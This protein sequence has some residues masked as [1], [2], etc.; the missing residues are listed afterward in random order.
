MSASM[1]LA[2][3]LIAVPV[4]LLTLALRHFVPLMRGLSAPLWAYAFAPVIFFSDRYFSEAARP[5]RKKFLA[6]VGAFIL[7]C[8]LLVL[9]IGSSNEP[10]N[11]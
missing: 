1:V 3:L 7:I 8:V 4:A 9:S 5:H 2:A 10:S 11:P 6:Y